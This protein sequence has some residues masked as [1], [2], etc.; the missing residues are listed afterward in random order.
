MKLYDVI[1]GECV[2]RLGGSLSSRGED[3]SSRPLQWRE[4]VSAGLKLSQP[5][6]SRSQMPVIHSFCTVCVDQTVKLKALNCYSP[7]YY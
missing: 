2:E 4:A 6:V 3:V 7:P 1:H 5:R